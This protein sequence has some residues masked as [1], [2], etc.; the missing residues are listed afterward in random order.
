MPN[1]SLAEVIRRLQHC[2]N[3]LYPDPYYH[4]RK[5]RIDRYPRKY[6]TIDWFSEYTRWL[7][8]SEYLR[9]TGG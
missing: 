5:T 4:M 9:T 7:G 3:P 6:K 8:D 1:I 2:A